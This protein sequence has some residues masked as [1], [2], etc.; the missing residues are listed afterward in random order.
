MA[1]PP[2][3][4]DHYLK[5]A[6]RFFMLGNPR[7]NE[8]PFLLT[9]GVLLFRWHNLLAERFQ[10]AHPDWDDERVFLTAR[11]W[12][13]ATH[14]KIVLYDWLPAWLNDTIPDYEG[15][16]SSLHPGISHEFQSAAMRFGH[17]L[18]PPGVYR[19]NAMCEFRNTSMATGVAGHHGL[20]TCNTYWNPQEAVEES[21]IDEI[22]MGMASQIAEREDN[23][24]TEDLRGKVFGPLDFSRR[25][26]MAINIQRGRDHGL[27]DYNTARIYYGL[28]PITDWKDINPFL[29]SLD[30]DLFSRLS[31]VHMGNISHVDI[32]TGGLLETMPGGPGPLFNAIIK[33][34][35]LRIR[36]GDRFWFENEKNGLFTEEERAMVWNITLYDIILNVT[37]I[38]PGDI[39]EDVFH[40]SSGDPCPQPKQLNQS[41]ME[42]CTNLQT[43]DYFDGSEMWYIGS[44]GATGAFIVCLLLVVFLWF[45]P[46]VK[47]RKTSKMKKMM[48]KAKPKTRVGASVEDIQ[49]MKAIEW[50]GKDS[51]RNVQIKFGPGNVMHIKTGGGGNVRSLNFDNMQE[52]GLKLAIDNGER[53]VIISF[54]KEYDLALIFDNVE[55]RESFLEELGVVLE[56]A[57]TATKQES[58]YQWKMKRNAYT[59]KQRQ[60]K[61]E[62]FFKILFKKV[63]MEEFDISD[64]ES[65]RK[66]KDVLECELTLAEFAESLAMKCDDGFVQQMFTLADKDNSGYISFKEFLQLVIIFYRGTSD[67]KCKM[68]FDLYD[69]DGSGKLHKQEFAEMMKNTMTLINADVSE[70]NMDD[71][72]DM[73]FKKADAAE[74]NELSFDDF[75]I[76]LGNYKE[77]FETAVLPVRGAG[78]ITPRQ[79]QLTMN[80]SDAQLFRQRTFMGQRSGSPDSGISDTRLRVRP[81][82]SKGRP[83]TKVY[84]QSQSYTGR[85]LNAFLRYM[86]NHRLEI[87]YLFIYVFVVAGIF[88]ERAY[89]F[90]FEREHRGLRRIAGYGVTVTRG[91][92]SVIMFTMSAMLVTMCRNTITHLRGTFL[93]KFIPFD[94]AVNFHKIIAGTFLLFTCVHITGHGINF[95]HISTQ[96]ADDL[97]CLFRDYFHRSHQ[98]PKFQYWLFNTTTGVT[99]VMLVVVM[100]I[101]MVFAL[102]I[103]RRYV[104][105]AFWI[106]HK[107]YIPMYI[108]TIL[109][110]SGRLVIEPIFHYFLLG[111]LILYVL[112]KLVSISRK[113]VEVPI[114]K[115]EILPSGVTY[116][117]WK[118]PKDFEYKSGQWIR[119][120]SAA[121]GEHEYH[122]F[123]LTSAPHEDKLSVYVRAVGPWTMNLQQKYDPDNV[124]DGKYPKLY[125]DGPFGEGHQDW[126]KYEVSVLIGAGIGV[127]PFA[128]ILK[129]V[130]HQSKTSAQFLCKKVYFFWVTRTQRQFEWMMDIL[131]NIER[132]DESNL[133]DTHIFITQFYQKF[134]LR[135]TMLYIC[136][137]NFQTMSSKSLFTGLQ[138]V[139]HFGR[140]DFYSIM[141]SVQEQHE[142]DKIGVFSCGPP[143]LTSSVED[144]CSKLNSQDDVALF[145]HYYENF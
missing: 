50:R 114:V 45:I 132:D 24:I 116:L 96:T 36:D 51:D 25:D 88:I 83:P 48:N 38:Q 54:Q 112:D 100:V 43:Y 82:T 121:L 26:L 126:N 105:N 144:A 101:L 28:D 113:R 60:K 35:F 20:R 56:A 108:L 131:R 84:T 37:N 89:Y 128:S 33:S 44:F 110:G 17:T 64:M 70:E 6:K 66:I 55:E 22:L 122:P 12:V 71:M 119:L 109:H 97:T 75:M 125:L 129:D 8:N 135:T 61:L 74:E 52:I 49:M 130:V 115:S 102:P 138:A 29:Y 62:K 107:L 136:E 57:G 92:A 86:E 65:D 133:V 5:D 68:L 67:E 34:Q 95:Y 143:S 77:N 90:S 72:V 19:R 141:D 42:P 21:D 63:S 31:D 118:R 93:C 18:V 120:S 85:K 103:T 32:W 91:A 123:T 9:F 124:T 13:I 46:L 10:Q 104:Y 41:D 58:M 39:Q 3:P 59:Y 40:W 27:P 142:V 98:L 11:K 1:N 111:P 47:Y 69:L 78:A 79:V 4:R 16:K 73:M 30:P 2:P 137:R 99:G 81:L 7:G 76:A 139:T 15:Y 140:P 87:F 127:T 14:Q 80:G 106:T 23:I 145:A 134:D 94:S 53:M 117:E